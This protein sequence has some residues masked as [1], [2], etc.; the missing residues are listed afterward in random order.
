M[1]FSWRNSQSSAAQELARSVIVQCGLLCFGDNPAGIKAW[2]AAVEFLKVIP[3]KWDDISFID[4]YPGQYTC[5][6]RKS[7]KDWYIGAGNAS[8]SRQLSIKL[9]FLDK[10]GIYTG[11]LFTGSG[12][13]SL[14]AATRNNLRYDSTINVS[15]A[16]GGGFV[17]R[18]V[19][20]DSI[21]VAVRSSGSPSIAAAAGSPVIRAVTA[22]EGTSSTSGLAGAELY[23]I[24]G[25]KIRRLPHGTVKGATGIL[26][27]KQRSG[28]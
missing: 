11:R 16:G 4:G 23:D 22:L 3:T 1:V 27:I 19:K 18:L 12:W 25:K 10:N 2:P 26:I 14:N 8:T 13:T 9:D 28:K 20:T 21:T 15:L 6:A 5:L 17:A 24:S 7:G